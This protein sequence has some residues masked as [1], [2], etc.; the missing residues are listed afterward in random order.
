MRQYIALVFDRTAQS[1]VI[2]CVQARTRKEIGMMIQQYYQKN[3]WEPNNLVINVYAASIPKGSKIKMLGLRS[4]G[5]IETPE[6]A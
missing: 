1:D 2:F 5:E 4:L 6:D 3:H